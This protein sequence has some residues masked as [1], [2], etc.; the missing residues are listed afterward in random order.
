LTN[1]VETNTN[2]SEFCDRR[3]DAEINHAARMQVLDPPKATLLWQKVGRDLLAAAAM[4]PTYNG[5]AIVFLGKRV[6]NFQYHPQ[7]MTLLDQLWVR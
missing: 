7:W 3:I 2:V 4:V 6:G 5:R 1:D